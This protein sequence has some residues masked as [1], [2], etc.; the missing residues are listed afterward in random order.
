MSWGEVDSQIKE[1]EKI[2]AIQDDLIQKHKLVRNRIQMNVDNLKKEQPRRQT[3]MP[4]QVIFCIF[5]I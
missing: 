5:L 4:V 2:I 3:L 1:L